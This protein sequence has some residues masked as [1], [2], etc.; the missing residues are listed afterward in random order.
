MTEAIS[1]DYE[2]SSEGGV[3]H[4]SVPY[5]RLEDATPTATNPAS[6]IDGIAA[7]TGVQITGTILTV[8]ATNSMAIVDFTASMV[9]RQSVRNVTT[10]NLGGESAWAAIQLGA[11]I[12]YDRSATMP[13]GTYLSLAAADVAGTNNPLFG[14]AVPWSEADMAS[15]PKL[16]LGA[17][18]TVDVAVMQ[19]GSGS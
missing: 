4:W 12:Y 11:P 16:P 9:Y 15:F 3:R 2:V 5:A 19:R 8:D 10:Y 18:G 13:V 6:V 7:G 17:A 14:F 1:N